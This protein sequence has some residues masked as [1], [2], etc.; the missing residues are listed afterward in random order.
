MSADALYVLVVLAATVALFV[1]DR[2]RLELVAVLATLALVLGGQIDAT[3]AVA[4]LGD[5]VVV[6]IAALFVV[7]EAL[8]R[9]GVAHRVGGFL[10][11]RAGAE[12]RRLIALMMA[13]V[14]V[15]SAFMS[16]TG[17]V[18]VFIPIALGLAQRTGIARERLL[19]PL[20]IAAMIGGMLTLIGTPPN[21]VVAAELRRAG[22]EPFGFFAFT[23][24]GAVVL[25]AGIAYMAVIGARLLGA[26][27]GEAGG[28]RPTIRELIA[29]HDLMDEVFLVRVPAGSRLVGQAVREARLIRRYGVTVVG[30]RRGKGFRAA[31][32]ETRFE[33][34]DLLVV[35]GEAGDIER[36][37]AVEGVLTLPFD[38]APPRQSDD[39]LGVVEVLVSPQSQVVGRTVVQAGFRE[40]HGL[41]VQSVMRGGR[42]VRTPLAELTLQGGDVLLMAGSWGAIRRLARERPNLFVLRLPQEADDVAPA[43]TKAPIALAVTG[44]MIAALTLNLLPSVIVVLIAAVALVL[45]GCLDMPAVYRAIN[46]QS[47]LLIAFMLPMATALDNSGALDL[48]V[49]GLVGGLGD[50][51]PMA[52]LAVLFLLTSGLSQVISNTATT[53]LVAPVALSAA[54]QLDVSPYSLLMGV[55]IAA[56]TAFATPV[57]SPV[58]TLVLGPGRYRFTD[59]LKVGVP[60]QLVA[61]GLCLALLPVLFPF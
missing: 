4:G 12:E 42:R 14:A 58:N 21:L 54:Q 23:P 40:V 22:L 45:S 38:E 61:L 50:A 15:L 19:M 29:A 55:A 31:S 7:G 13:A 3:E 10:V 57:A 30:V 36:F 53:V 60:L 34:G 25:V 20:A 17:A 39:D 46:W 56:S 37:K 49:D 33:A 41:V 2:I 6:L 18:A 43:R 1:S 9:T 16:S 32:P 5:R 24:I 11:A 51:G 26:R 44:L 59:F 48:V 35:T 8:F 47:V 28:A 52:L 27:G